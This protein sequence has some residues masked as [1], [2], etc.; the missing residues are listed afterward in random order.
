MLSLNYLMQVLVIVIVAI[1][2]GITAFFLALGIRGRIKAGYPVLNAKTLRWLFVAS[3][4]L[5]IE[6]LFVHGLLFGHGAGIAPDITPPSEEGRT[7]LN[8]E[9]P[10]EPTAEELAADREAKKPEHL[11]QQDEPPDEARQQANEY[12][13][14]ALERAKERDDGR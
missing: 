14:A 6:G 4:L 5:T 10:D 12:I 13:E 8:L 3:L 1:L 7:E 2:F 9:K 11:R